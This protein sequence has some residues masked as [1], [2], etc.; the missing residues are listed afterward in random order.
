MIAVKIYRQRPINIWTDNRR[1][2]RGEHYRFVNEKR[3]SD[4]SNLKPAI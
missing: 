4:L 2:S 3:N 1:D